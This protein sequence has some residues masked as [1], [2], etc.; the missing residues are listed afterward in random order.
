MTLEMRD[1]LLSKQALRS[2]LTVLPIAEKLRLLD[3]LRERS[4]DIAASRAQR[5]SDEELLESSARI[6]RD[7][8]FEIE[9]TEEVFAP[10]AD[11][12]GRRRLELR[13]LQDAAGDAAMSIA[14]PLGGTAL[15]VPKGWLLT[16]V[17][18]VCDTNG[19]EVQTGPFGS[20]LHAHD[21]CDDGIPVV[22]PQDLVDGTVS[23]KH[24]AR[25]SPADVQRLSRH[26]LRVDD[27]LYSRRG[28][29]TRF[30][31][32]ESREEGWMCGTGCMRIR[33]NAPD[34]FPC[35]L[36]QYLRHHTVRGWLEFQAKGATMPNLNT[37]ILRSLPLLLPPLS[38]QKR[39]AGIL[40]QA[41]GLRRKR[42]QALALTDQFL[43]ST[44]LDLFG[45]P[46]TNPK[47]WPTPPICEVGKV[48]TG[49]TPPGESEGMFGG[50]V[51]F[52]TPGD[53]ESNVASKRWLTED[54]ARN[55]RVVRAGS[56]LVCCIGATIGK[57]GMADIESAFNQQLNAVE[58]GPRIVDEYGYFAV[59]L[60]RIKV[61]GPAISTTL[62][63]LKKSSFEKVTIPV[64][65][66]ELQ[67]K[68]AKVYRQSQATIATHRT[69]RQSFDT[70]FD[71]LVQRAFRGE[72]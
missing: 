12:S 64:P 44:F 5:I 70:L 39:I 20:Q 49:A 40:D 46:V 71:A 62:P 15:P 24:V 69:S 41:S 6:A 36:S 58:C 27:V 31:I 67:S 3:Q 32:I 23:V 7:A 38:E 52:I 42:Q 45:D 30:A 16:T 56:T 60:G 47:R 43:R 66:R 61:I 19:G 1:I 18:T 28:D 11:S 2:R 29:V 65:P 50:P 59:S 26:Q 10:I 51:P 8:P 21:Y 53:L 13:R 34:I 55:S 68:F 48:T 33:L 72:L 35:Y 4:L 57:T 63:I 37:T 17:G 22:M 9:Q 14:L 25:I 54:G